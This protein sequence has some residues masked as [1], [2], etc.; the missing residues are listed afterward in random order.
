[1]G[2][3]YTAV[4]AVGKEF[5][6]TGEAED[7]LRS[8]G[9][10]KEYTDEEIEGCLEGCTPDGLT[11]ESLNLYT[12]GYY[13]LGIRLNPRDVEG[14]RKAFEDATSLWDGYFPDAPADMIHTVRVS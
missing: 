4:L 1:M 2:T 8:A 11:F 5:E 7:F 6:S 10:L 9:H 12:G 13:Y 3:S 14:F